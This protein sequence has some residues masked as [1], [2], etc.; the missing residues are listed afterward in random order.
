MQSP[1][2]FVIGTRIPPRKPLLAAL[3]TLDSV[4]WLVP[5]PCRASLLSANQHIRELRISV[6]RGPT[7][8]VKK[9]LTLPL[10][11]GQPADRGR[12][13]Q[14]NQNSA[15]GFFASASCNDC[16]WEKGSRISRG[17]GLGDGNRGIA[18]SFCGETSFRSMQEK[19]G[20]QTD[21]I[22]PDGYIEQGNSKQLQRH[23]RRDWR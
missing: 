22:R 14:L 21:K 12:P 11:I 6:A 8:F 3:H 5:N 4:P 18:D 20:P 23:L 13:L 16:A 15:R 17:N 1:R 7:S 19:L 10:V 2:K 9:V